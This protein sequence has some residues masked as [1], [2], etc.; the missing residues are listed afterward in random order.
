LKINGKEPAAAELRKRFSDPNATEEQIREMATTFVKLA[1]EGT[2]YEA[3][4]PN[5]TYV[6]SKVCLSAVTPIQQRQFDKER[7]DDDIVVNSVH[8]GYVDT[9]MTS[10]QGPLSI[11]QGAEAAV[12]LAQLPPNV[13]TPRGQYVWTNKAIVDWVNG[14]TP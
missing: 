1:Q 11:D 5:S 10:H 4:W 14:P 12:W 3:G 2:H 13:E 9:D 8:P 7:P 6:V